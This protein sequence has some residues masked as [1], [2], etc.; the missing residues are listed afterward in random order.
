M[1]GVKDGVR[2]LYIRRF[3]RPEATEVVASSNQLHRVDRQ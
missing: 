2:R 3:D 1:I